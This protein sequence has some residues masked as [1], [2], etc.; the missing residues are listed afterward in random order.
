MKKLIK[1]FGICLTMFICSNSFLAAQ[2][3][4][5]EVSFFSGSESS[6]TDPGGHDAGQD[7]VT[8]PIDG[9]LILLIVAGVFVAYRFRNKLI[10]NKI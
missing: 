9:Y 2:N 5:V 8:A 1:T 10:Q 3:D 6:S 4:E 7:P